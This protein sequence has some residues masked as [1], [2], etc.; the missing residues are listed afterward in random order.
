MNLVGYL[1]FTVLSE[2]KEAGVTMTWA[3]A[4][5]TQKHPF[6]FGFY[7]SSI[8][9]LNGECFCFFL[10]LLNA[11]AWTSMDV[12]CTL[13]YMRKET[14]CMLLGIRK[15]EVTFH[16]GVVSTILAF[17]KRTLENHEEQSVVYS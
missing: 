10:T 6:L 9:L 3:Y 15:E 5:Y 16:L 1:K 4:A 11:A 17:V 13:G 2:S 12:K 7:L 14:K 8:R